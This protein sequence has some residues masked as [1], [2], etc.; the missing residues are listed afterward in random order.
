MRF[1]K[2]IIVDL[3]RTEEQSNGYHEWSVESIKRYW[4]ICTSNSFIRAQ[5]YPTDYWE[6]LLRWAAMRIS[7]R[8]SAIVDVGCGNGNLIDCIAKMYRDTPI[9]GVDLSAESFEPAIQRFHNYKH[10]R[11]R[12]GS[13]DRLPLEDGSIDLITCTEVLE[14]TF[15]ETFNRSFLEVKRVLKKNGYFLASV[16][17]NEKINFVC[18]PGCG[19]VFTPHQHMIFEISR[20]DIRRLLSE[21]SLELID[22][23]QSLDRSQPP[24]LFKRLLK[25]IIIKWLPGFATRIFP[26]AGV[27]GFLAR[28]MS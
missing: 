5:F 23:Y 28:K 25:P 7:V 24:N 27:S 13:L 2:D 19:S 26:K 10:V 12:V 1:Y 3:E 6:D 16:P 11:F 18:C 8:P 14:H 17:F 22:Y 20:E 9:Y 4:N 21:N 15:P